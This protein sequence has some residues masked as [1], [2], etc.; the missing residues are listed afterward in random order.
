MR[1]LQHQRLPYDGQVSIERLFAEIRSHLPYDCE[2]AEATSP[3]PSTGFLP[4]LKN[5][6][7]ARR[8]RAD[9]HHIVGDAH[10]LAFGLP[11]KCM[12]LTIHDCAALNRLT[13]WKHEILRYFW[14]TG[15]M[16]RA[17]V[18]TTISETT[19]EELRKWV[20]DLADTVEVVPNCV[21]SEFIPDPRPWPEKEPL[22]L[23]VGT[24]WNKNVERVAEAL[25]G[26][27]CRLEIVGTLD[28]SQKRAL[29]QTGVSFTELGRL[30]DEQLLAAYRRSDFLVFAS[31]YE[32][33]G[34]PI[35]EAQAIG[36]PVI[37][38]NRSSMPEAAGDGAL[39]VDP[40]SVES[41]R[42]AVLE[43]LHRPSTREELIAKGYVNVEKYRP[44]AIAAQYAAIYQRFPLGGT[45]LAAE[46]H[47]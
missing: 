39:F 2:V 38:S 9:V 45:A 30:S 1:I 7:C 31:L 35:L 8:Q 42:R 27:T 19:K 28:E 11:G 15:P 18:V 47:P 17:A 14:F 43:L 5:L 16:R 32:G 24:A 25:K 33:F 26:T 36:R 40:E 37:T 46:K 12:V 44:A 41:I 23:Q 22:C 20:G 3:F 29:Q 10:Y 21:R 34:L 4:R 6:L 13:G